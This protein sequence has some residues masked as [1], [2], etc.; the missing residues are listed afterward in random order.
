MADE[1]EI[2]ERG[3]VDNRLL[4]SIL[5]DIRR[6]GRETKD[7]VVAL[8]KHL[9]DV[10]KRNERRF[11]DMDKRF[12]DLDQRFNELRDD[13]ELMIKSELMGRLMHFETRIDQK[14]D[15]LEEQLGRK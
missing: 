1:P 2:P 11:A 13:L 15:E 8:T 12:S 5:R 9:F 6:D 7:L 3:Q 10:E 4:A 14:I